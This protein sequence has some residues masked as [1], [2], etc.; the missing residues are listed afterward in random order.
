MSMLAQLLRPAPPLP[1]VCN[2]GRHGAIYR[3]CLA[4]LENPRPFAK[5]ATIN[6]SKAAT[7]RKRIEAMLA[8][9][10]GARSMREIAERIQT[11]YTQTRAYVRWLDEQGLCVID[12]ST[13]PRTIRPARQS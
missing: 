12:K 4:E 6:A 2:P 1:P 10:A 8:I 7:D 11:G 3:H 9:N 13:M 5:P